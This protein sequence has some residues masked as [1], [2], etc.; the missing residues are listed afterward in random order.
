M[1]NGKMSGKTGGKSENLLLPG[2]FFFRIA[3]AFSMP[4]VNSDEKFN[5]YF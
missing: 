4:I 2:N 3:V 5:K 1:E